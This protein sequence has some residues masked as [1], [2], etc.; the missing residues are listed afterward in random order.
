MLCIT[1]LIWSKSFSFGFSTPYNPAIYTHK[2]NLFESVEDAM[3]ANPENVIALKVNASSKNMLEIKKF[4]NLR[5]MVLDDG[6]TTS[7]FYLD[8]QAFKAFFEIC[9]QL[10]L[11]EYLDVNDAKLI[12]YI[13]EPEKLKGLK[14][15]KYDWNIFQANIS[16]FNNLEILIIDDQ[17]VTNLPKAVGHI[18]SL[19]QLELY[20]ESLPALPELNLL[21]NLL[22]I[23][24]NVGRIE[25]LPKTFGELKSVRYLSLTG[26]VAFKDFPPEILEMEGLEEL[27]IELRNTDEIPADISK[28]SKLKSLY[29]VDCNRIRELPKSMESLSKLENITI[30]GAPHKLDISSL[31]NLKNDISITLI[32]CNYANFAEQLQNAKNL[33]EFIIPTATMPADVKKI[34]KYIPKNKIK[35]IDL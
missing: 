34:E 7:S 29:L 18:K 12:P 35:K 3:N 16:R 15:S 27:K 17:K 11:L 14:I 2:A 31:L 26:L 30:T 25:K 32:R 1:V 24:A 22:V 23:K 20:T 28:L 6:F 33:K 4:Q 9:N 5:F 10:P 13:K 21:S 19:Q 8:E